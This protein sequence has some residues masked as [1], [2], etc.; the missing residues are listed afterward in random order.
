MF[1]SIRLY[2][3]VI[4]LNVVDTNNT[5]PIID[6]GVYRKILIHFFAFVCADQEI[7][8]GWGCVGW[9]WFQRY[10]FVCKEVVEEGESFGNFFTL[11]I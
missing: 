10:N 7:S 2:L 1:N 3:H 4:Q 6:I 5:T 8:K 9:G 11:W